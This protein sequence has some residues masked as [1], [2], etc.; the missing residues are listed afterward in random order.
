[1]DLKKRAKYK[2]PASNKRIVSIMKI[3]ILT[4]FYF[5]TYMPIDVP[6]PKN[7]LQ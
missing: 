7:K 5:Q 4:L 1:M 6:T 2:S 3:F